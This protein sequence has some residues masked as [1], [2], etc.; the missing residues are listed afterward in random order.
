MVRSKE[1]PLIRASS[2]LL[3]DLLEIVQGGIQSADAAALLHSALATARPWSDEGVEL[4]ID[5]VAAGKAAAAMAGTVVDVY[6]DRLRRGVVTA[7]PPDH[8]DRDSSLESERGRA[9]L[10]WIAASHPLP[11]EASLSA[12]RRALELAEERDGRAGLLVLLSGGASSMLAVPGVGVTLAEKIET[13][14]LL[15]AAGAAIDDFNVVRKHLSGIKGGRLAAAAAGPVQAYAVSD[16]VVPVEDDPS[17]IGSGP[18]VPDP[19]SFA[20]AVRVVDA[21]ELRSR[22]PTSVVAMLAAGCR[23]ERSETPKPGDPRL[24][25]AHL[26]VAGNRHDAMQGAAAVAARLGYA[27]VTLSDPVIGEA[28]IAAA[29]L[30]EHLRR[31]AGRGGRPICVLSSGETTVRIVGDGP[32]G[33]NQELALALVRALAAFDADVAV[34][35]VGTDGVDGPTEAAGAWADRTTLERAATAGLADPESYLSRNDSNSY[36]SAL[37]NLIVTGPT[38]TNVGDLQVALIASR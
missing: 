18:T 23:G 12:G 28:R 27:T 38:S 26:T 37:G 16:V 17:V 32:G 19:T 15:L 7:A 35:S 24:G 11:D 2:R 20:D 31:V 13:S 22:L 33:R 25:Q 1:R 36:F 34:A 30:I 5:I 29:A 6:G 21:Y 10:E 4:P 14:R 3:R 9:G 8:G